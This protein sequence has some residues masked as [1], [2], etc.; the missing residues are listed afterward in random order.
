MPTSPLVFQHASTPPSC[1]YHS[2]PDRHHALFPSFPVAGPLSANFPPYTP[3]NL[4]EPSRSTDSDDMSDGVGDVPMGSPVI[5][6]DHVKEPP[7]AGEGILGETMVSR[8]TNTRREH[9]PAPRRREL[10]R[11]EME[12]D[13]ENIHAAGLGTSPPAHL[14]SYPHPFAGPSGSSSTVYQSRLYNNNSR[15]NN[16]RPTRLS[17]QPF[18]HAESDAPTPVRINTRPSLQFGPNGNLLGHADALARLA[19]GEQF[20]P[21]SSH[22]AFIRPSRP[23]SRQVSIRPAGSI[24]SPSP[25]HDQAT[26]DAAA[27][28]YDIP[29]HHMRDLN[30]N[31]LRAPSDPHLSLP[32][33]SSVP[34]PRPSP[35]LATPSSAIDSEATDFDSPSVSPGLS[36]N[37]LGNRTVPHPRSYGESSETHTARLQRYDAVRTRSENLYT[38]G[39]WQ[40]RYEWIDSLPRARLGSSSRATD[41]SSRQGRYSMDEQR[42]LRSR[43]GRSS[44]PEEES[45][46][47]GRLN[48]HLQTAVGRRVSGDVPHSPTSSARRQR[49]LNTPYPLP[50]SQWLR[51][52]I[53]RRSSFEEPA[54]AYPQPSSGIRWGELPIDTVDSAPHDPM[55]MHLPYAFGWRD[56]A[57]FTDPHGRVLGEDALDWEEDT[58]YDDDDEIPGDYVSAGHRPVRQPRSYLRPP[59]EVRMPQLRIHPT[60]ATDAQVDVAREI[61]RLVPRT[62]D[63]SRQRGAKAMV[64]S[65]PWGELEG[66]PEMARDV[67]CSVC[68]D[69]VSRD[70]S[71]TSD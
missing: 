51:A 23:S 19:A 54:R 42:D 6:D 24:P 59:D 20:S 52:H 28:A 21:L 53:G 64:K 70:R 47:M 17:P 12:V 38:P 10:R 5:T 68:Y 14:A 36:F 40:H 46:P 33:L 56:N 48:R 25:S 7:L 60:M 71:V 2:P 66:T 22:H 30:R 16:I 67:F 35:R 43:V 29:G 58:P 57:E 62:S 9:S 27:L 34:P 3:S 32:F 49:D 4:S 41:V 37:F 13:A 61:A 39:D 15:I 18:I 69:E 65:V 63:R 8:P 45:D 26:E 55:R 31:T 44:Q 50:N 11:E 1:L